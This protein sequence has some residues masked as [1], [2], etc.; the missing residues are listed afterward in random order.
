MTQF[1]QAAPGKGWLE[2]MHD[3]AGI[4]DFYLEKFRAIEAA[5]PEGVERD[6]ARAMVAHETAINKFAKLEIAG[7]G[8]NSVAEMV[9]QLH[10]P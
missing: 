6:M 10:W 3:V 1:T 7:E 2:H 9:A 8:A 5:A 4:T